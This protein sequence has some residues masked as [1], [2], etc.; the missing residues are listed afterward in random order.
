LRHT[1]QN[2][3]LLAASYLFYAWWDWRFLGLMLLST[4][5][6]YVVGRGL[7]ALHD[8]RRRRQL[9]AISLCVNLGILGFFKYFNFFVDS[10]ERVTMAL[11]MHFPTPALRILL[12]VGISFYTFHGISYTFDVY[13]RN[14]APARR[15]LDFALFVAFFPQLVAGPSGHH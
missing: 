4:V 10:A 7:G 2:S 8:D 14:I 13:R 11:G 9:F 3:L 5:T 1:G 15:M 12:P 6:D